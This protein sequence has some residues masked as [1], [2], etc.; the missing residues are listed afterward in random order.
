MGYVGSRGQSS[1]AGAGGRSRGTL[2]LAPSLSSVMMGAQLSFLTVLKPLGKEAAAMNPQWRSA[3]LREEWKET[4]DK[5][6]LLE[7]EW[8]TMRL[9]G[10]SHREAS[11]GLRVYYA[12]GTGNEDIGSSRMGKLRFGEVNSL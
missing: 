3:A 9:S 4:E 8:P 11:I 6:C 12:P 7:S 2:R 1:W 5:S 10:A